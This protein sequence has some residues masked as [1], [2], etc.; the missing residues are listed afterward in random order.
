M[1]TITG[2]FTTQSDQSFPHDCEL[3][4]GMQSNQFL[5]HIIGNVAGDKAVLY[6]CEL[7]NGNA[8][9]KA[10]YVFVRTKAHPEGEVLWFE[11][12][13]VSAGMFIKTEAVSV[14][15]QGKEYPQAYTVRWLAVG[16]G[17][18]SFA[19]SDFKDL[20]TLTEL[21]AKLNGQESQL[22][23]I[24]VPPIGIIYTWAGNAVP[25][26]YLLCDGSQYLQAD[27]PELYKVIGSVYN[28]TANYAGNPQTT[29][30][31]YFRIPDLRGRFIVGQSS[32]DSNY[33]SHGSAG[34]SKSVTLTSSQMP[35]HVHSFKD[36]YYIEGSPGGF[37]GDD[38]VAKRVGAGRTD[39][40]N[41]HL[42]YYTHDTNPAG[43]GLAHENRPPY[44]T[45]SY[46][47]R[48]K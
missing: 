34:G 26:G 17:S 36:Y 12:G 30:S 7:E 18:E 44:Y 29:N 15:V 48:A 42:W 40:D 8:R 24:G 28:T 45:L 21:L 14:S 1:K 33:G 20:V 35:A 19:W 47:I 31:G 38:P 32:V 3:Y 25:E 5:S 27:Y 23:Q 41:T 46:I 13:N 10:G 22:T 9:R 6:G 4:E 16:S 11:G 43:D 39:S 2:H 37:S